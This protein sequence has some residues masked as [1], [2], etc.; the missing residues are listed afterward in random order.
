MPP[1]R[2]WHSADQTVYHLWHDCS[3]AKDVTTGRR[4]GHGDRPLCAECALVERA[5]ASV[6]REL[7]RALLLSDT[8]RAPQGRLR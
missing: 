5:T 7:R 4:P 8:T 2:S 1:T 6:E 3:A